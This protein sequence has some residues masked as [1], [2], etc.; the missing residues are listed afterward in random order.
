M[1]PME[2]VTYVRIQNAKKMLR[3]SHLSVYEIAERVGF[4]DC[5]Y[6]C[7]IF[8]QVEGVTPMQYAGR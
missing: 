6:F 8:R 5:S 3:Y 1:R 2:Y 7:K 4:S